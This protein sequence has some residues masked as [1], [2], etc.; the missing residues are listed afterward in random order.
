AEREMRRRRAAQIVEADAPLD[1]G[2]HERALVAHLAALAVLGP[3]V[4]VAL[5]VSRSPAVRSKEVACA[6][7]EALELLAEDRREPRHHGHAV[8]LLALRDPHAHA[9]ARDLA[10][11]LDVLH[12]DRAQVVGSQGEADRAGVGAPIAGGE[13][14]AREELLGLGPAEPVL[15]QIARPR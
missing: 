7:H 3:A 6:W 5:R 4:V 11:E 14:G 13:G 10:V 2:S 8:P 9:G 1:A 15:G 12:L